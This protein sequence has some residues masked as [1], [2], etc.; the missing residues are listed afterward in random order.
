MPKWPIIDDEWHLSNHVPCLL[1]TFRAL[2]M[3]ESSAWAWNTCE[4]IVKWSLQ[5]SAPSLF[6]PFFAPDSSVQIP[7][8]SMTSSQQEAN[9]SLHDS[10][11]VTSPACLPWHAAY[12]PPRAIAGSITRVELLRWFKEGRR[13]GKDFVLI[14]LRRTDLEVITR[15]ILRNFYV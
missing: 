15:P 7:E 12:P 3:H 13:V 8:N 9:T 11:K 5:F 10:S 6:L 2:F 14:D 4:V 1:A